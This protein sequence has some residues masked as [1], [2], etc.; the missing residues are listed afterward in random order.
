MPTASAMAAPAPLEP[1]QA[2]RELDAAVDREQIFTLLLR[3]TLSRVPF[4][5]LLSV[6]RNGFR[7]RRALAT[8]RFDASAVSGL[9]IP[10]EAV[11]AFELAVSTRASTVGRIATGVPAI[12]AQLASLGNQGTPPSALVL[13]ILVAERPVALVIGH[14]G[15]ETPELEALADLMPLATETGVAL[16]RLLALRADAAAA[17]PT[18]LAAT[19]IGAVLDEELDDVEAQ[20]RVLAVCR[21]YESWGELAD[22]IRALLRTGLEKGEPGEDEQLELLLELG[23][24]EADHLGRPEL[25]IEA[26]RSAQTI[27]A[28]NARVSEKLGR[29]FVTLERW[30]DL[31]QLLEQRAALADDP[32]VRV[33]VLGQVAA[34]AK[35]RLL[36]DER[37]IETYERIRSWMPGHS[38]ATEKLEELYRAHGRWQPLAALLLDVAARTGDARARLGALESAAQICEEQLGDPRAAFLVWLTVLRREPRHARGLDALEQL[39]SEARAWPELVPE[40]EAL[41]TELDDVD[42]DAA[43]ALWQRVGRWKRD[44]LGLPAEAADAFERSLRHAPEE[45]ELLDE[46]LTIRRSLGQSAELA[47]ALLRRS[48]IEL[49]PARRSALLVELGD[50]FANRLA[51]PAEAVSAYERAVAADASSEPALRGLTRTLR[52]GQDWEPLVPALARL[53]ELVDGNEK[54]ALHLE[55]AGLL[56]ERL[57]RTDEAAGAWNDALA[58][59]P[60][61]VTALQ[62]LAK[63]HLS[64]GRTEDYLATLEAE[65]D[66]TSSPADAQRYQE[67]ASGWEEHGQLERAAGCWQKLLTVDGRHQAA[68]IGLIRTLR[69]AERWPE[70]AAARRA[71]LSLVSN[72]SERA[73]VLL[74]LAQDLETREGR[75]DEALEAC[76]EALALGGDQNAAL[77]LLS[78]CFVRQGRWMDAIAMLERQLLKAPD[79]RARADLQQRIA[80]I[81]ADRDNLPS[82]WALYELALEFD[83]SNAGAHEGIAR[84]HAKKGDWANA[85]DHLRHAGQLR[86]QRSEAIG[87]LREA[88]ALYLERLGD[89][90]MAGDCLRRIVE[91]DPAQ[92]PGLAESLARTRQWTALWPHVA[93]QAE[94]I[95]EKADA[96]PVERRNAFLAA[97]RC[98]LE[99]GNSNEALAL[100]DRAV[101]I[102]PTHV[103]ALFERADALHRAGSLEPAARAFQSILAHQND[104]LGPRDRA[105]VYRKLGRVHHQLGQH[106]QT[107]A[108]YRKSLDIEPRDRD[109]LLALAELHLERE[110]FDEAVG[111][112]VS[113]AELTPHE[114]RLPILERIG[115]LQHEKLKNDGRAASTYLAALELDGSNRRIL[116]K[117]LD[118]QS[119]TGQ[120][121]AAIETIACFVALESDP[122][123][124]GKYRL[125]MA[126]IRRFKLK[127]EA[128][129]IDDY[130]RALEAFLDGNEP[131]A[132][133]P[134]ASALDAFENLDELCAGGQD[135]EG[136][137]RARRLLL[138]RLAIGDPL[139]V[140]LWDS[141]GAIQRT[142]LGQHEAAIIAY[143]TAHSLDP[144]KS[145]ERVR[146]LAELYTQI[147]KRSPARVTDHAARLLDVEPDNPEA[148]RAMGRACLEAGRIDEAWCVS[149]ALVFRQQ[150]TR[151]EAEF[152]RRYQEQERRKAKGV[153]D[154]ETWGQLRAEGEDPIVSAIFALVWETPVA[155]RAGPAKSFQLK[156]TERL[157]VEEG[158]R[159]VGKIF[160]NAAHALNAPLPHV[161]VQ[162]ERSGRLLL[163]NCIEDGALAPTV[164]V[165][166]D[167]MTGY[168]DTEIAF[169]VASTL[170]LLRPAWYLR[171]TLPAVAELEAA[172]YAAVALVR[173]D[174]PALS[175]LAKAFVP[176]MER[177]LTPQT[178]TLLSG[179]VERLAARPDLGRW[180]N[181]VDTAARRAALLVC[182][183]LESA[184]RMVA[185]EPIL[186]DGPK[187]KDKVRDLVLF[188][189]SP[190]YFAA[191][192]KLGLAVD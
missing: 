167:L 110:Q 25:A 4:A 122:R 179:L 128:A 160:R 79:A 185:A 188:S 53:A 20:R 62:G 15:N 173:E 8:G 106:V 31:V 46:L 16:K 41:A 132:E 116:Q 117:L 151:E 123:L 131:L 57:G 182:G 61:N 174:S 100:F 94:T 45:V 64:A 172:L 59:D 114:E 190:G 99:L 162:P 153:L 71:W 103:P 5:A 157:K 17:R 30:E 52:E 144:A 38:G 137:D 40:C 74:D 93:A 90:E 33:A 176:E 150:A 49:D 187:A 80:R 54:L 189:I 12:D 175:R 142:R 161:Y 192:R 11:P 37:A 118:I 111:A 155:L 56:D 67:L 86:G 13:P 158:S 1:Q 95:R 183:E 76:Q 65:L 83:S 91:F 3:A 96:S 156:S 130:R 44:H 58:I 35:V 186:P 6:E 164:I 18:P 152:Y 129:A 107:V 134:R 191:R 141:L 50:T 138:K 48:A 69:K 166:R 121:R 21:E 9:V 87:A 180:R 29:L 97:A 178:K 81:H 89:L 36:D 7:G 181:A 27:D 22:A 51:Q 72:P 14:G 139:L 159:T 109:T 75:L 120:W 26:W 125:A 124:R 23:A 85:A 171:L 82:A 154:D 146:I 115:D 136:Q 88:A 70:L 60:K 77:E 127:E 43:A 170:A 113:L 78:R 104:A 2:A 145:P 42:E 149:R 98:A 102:D 177:R 105:A 112:L 19:P 24:V 163:A 28:S 34:L 119:E 55:R 101:A 84:L 108:W 73:R 126:A 148:Y 39:G 47:S 32:E 68:R 140:T 66:A 143:E 10:R 147:G 63:L 165:A 168:K 92:A 184:A 133:G 135:W 169:C